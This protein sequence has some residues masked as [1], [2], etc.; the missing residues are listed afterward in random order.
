LVEQQ[1]PQRRKYHR[2]LLAASVGGR[3]RFAWRGHRPTQLS[4]A[5][6][7]SGGARAAALYSLICTARLNGV[8]PEACLRHVLANIADHL[9]NRVDDFLPWNGVAR[10][11][12]ACKNTPL[13]SG[14]MPSP[15]N[16][17]PPDSRQ[18]WLYAWFVSSFVSLFAS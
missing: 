9:V 7:D 3:T 4:V 2:Q 15:G 16:S 18:H 17:M 10:L 14:V 8:A 6:A 1:S 11:S 13:I 12:R 5:G